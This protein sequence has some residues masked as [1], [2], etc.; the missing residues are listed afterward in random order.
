MT[1]DDV[2]WTWPGPPLV[3]VIRLPETPPASG[4]IAIVAQ[5]GVAGVVV[6]AEQNGRIAF[7]LQHRPAVDRRLW[8]LP[9]GFGEP[10]DTGTTPGERALGT[11]ARELREET[12]LTIA[13]AQLLGPIY[14]DSGLLRNT[15]FVV[16][17]RAEGRTPTLRCEGEV[18]A[19]G[20]LDEQQIDRMISE[21]V[22]ADGITLAA[23]ALWR[24][25]KRPH[26]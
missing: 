18:D 22:L 3:Q 24:M 1:D 7:V 17:G 12:G 11:A 21:G 4:H 2:L 5:G 23:L 20:W 13:D 6:I 15:V 25:K 16:S 9:R 10:S 14:P 19:L 26:Q 8:E